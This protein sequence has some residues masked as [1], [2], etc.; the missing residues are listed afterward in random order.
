MKSSKTLAALLLFFSVFTAA[1]AVVLTNFS[2]TDFVVDSGSSSFSTITVSPTTVSVEGTDSGESLAG[3]F[4]PVDITGLSYISLTGTLSGAN[5]ESIF[6]VYLFNSTFDQY[7]LYSGTTASFGE[8]SSSLTLTFVQ[9]TAAFNDVAGFQFTTSGMG[10]PIVFTFQELS[11]S[12]TP[13]PST[14]VLLIGG[15]AV[16]GIIRRRSPRHALCRIH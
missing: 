5:P 4:D 3:T 16:A 14:W 13:E 2:E 6:S 12:A 15:I 9:E 8:L 10:A 11:A 1:H 7:R